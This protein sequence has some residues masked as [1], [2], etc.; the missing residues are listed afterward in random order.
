MSDTP[1]DFLKQPIYKG[2]RVVYVTG[3]T[4]PGITLA[5]V[6]DVER[7]GDWRGPPSRL[8]RDWTSG[9]KPWKI[10]VRRIRSDHTTFVPGGKGG[11]ASRYDDSDRVIS[12]IYPERIIVVHPRAE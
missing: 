1:L 2:A 10:K 12:L 5:D 9:S 3:G 6:V 8:R 7:T 11:P 4:S